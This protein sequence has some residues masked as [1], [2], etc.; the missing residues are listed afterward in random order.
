MILTHR[1]KSAFAKYS[2]EPN[3]S[4]NSSLASICFSI[5]QE[6][7][8]V[9]PTTENMHVFLRFYAKWQ[10]QNG[11]HSLWSYFDDLHLIVTLFLSGRS[12]PSPVP[13]VPYRSQVQVVF[14]SVNAV[15]SSDAFYYSD[16]IGFKMAAVM[17]KTNT[18]RLQ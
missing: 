5:S 4:H 2:L 15:K 17:F 14:L 3:L 9:N 18:P 11:N 10:S 8:F 7:V 12:W 13:R 16:I 1:R 6:C